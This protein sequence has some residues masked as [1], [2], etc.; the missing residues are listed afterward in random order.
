MQKSTLFFVPALALTLLAPPALAQRGMHQKDFPKVPERP[1]VTPTAQQKQAAQAFRTAHPEWRLRWNDRSR[2]PA[3]VLGPPLQVPGATPKQVAQTFLVQNHTL[4]GMSEALAGLELV[5]VE[6]RDRANHAIFQQ[7]H[8]GLP[9]EGAL[10]A[11]HLTKRNEVYYASG[12]HYDSV[13][14]EQTRPS[15]PVRK[16]GRIDM[17]I[18]NYSLYVLKNVN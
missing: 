7:T 11:V 15:V 18:G 3:S 6:K 4:F 13:R 16:D 8:A 1:A 2:T 5:R 10:Y 17:A 14:V 9:I 12:T